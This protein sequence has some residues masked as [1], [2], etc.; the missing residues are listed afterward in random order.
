MMF[1][2]M[3]SALSSCAALI[4][5]GVDGFPELVRRALGDD[6]DLVGLGADGDRGGGNEEHEQRGSSFFM[7]H[8]ADGAGQREAIG[9]EFGRREGRE[10]ERPLVEIH[11]GVQAAA[12]LKLRRRR[13][14]R[15]QAVERAGG[16]GEEAERVKMRAAHRLGLNDARQLVGREAQRPGV[17]PHLVRRLAVNHRPLVQAEAG[18]LRRALRR[19]AQQVR[20]PRHA[21]TTTRLERGDVQRHALRDLVVFRPA[22]KIAGGLALQHDVRARMPAAQPR[23]TETVVFEQEI[24]DRVLL[25]AGGACLVGRGPGGHALFVGAAACVPVG[26]GQDDDFAR[27][28][29]VSP[30]PAAG[31][32]PRWVAR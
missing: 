17:V 11:V 27:S 7:G 29:H 2:S 30:W 4:G 9:H 28:D 6:G 16:G 24:L 1:T 15:L 5:A 26:L 12:L 10:F 19:Q 32:R 8:L 25:A 13:T 23:R 20:D 31:A 22:E 21:F 14:L 18:E 3:P